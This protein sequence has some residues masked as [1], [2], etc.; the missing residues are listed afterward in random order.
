M[1]AAV[2]ILRGAGALAGGPVTVDTT[3]GGVLLI[4]PRGA[5]RTVTLVNRGTTPV[6]YRQTQD[7]TTGNGWRLPGI[8]GASVTLNFTGALYGIVGTG[9]QAID[10]I[11]E[12][13]P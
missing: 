6:Y 8:D 5:R 3:V 2:D 1:S 7:V 11:E 12:Y 10:V 13:D 4:A 9:S